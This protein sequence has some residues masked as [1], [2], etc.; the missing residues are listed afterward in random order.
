MFYRRARWDDKNR[1]A[2]FKR[3]YRL[4]YEIFDRLMS[5]RVPY[6]RRRIRN[7]VYT[8][9][10]YTVLWTE[11]TDAPVA[12]YTVRYRTPETKYDIIKR[13]FVPRTCYTPVM[14]TRFRVPLIY[15]VSLAV[16]NT[17]IRVRTRSKHIFFPPSL[18]GVIVGAMTTRVA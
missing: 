4:W 3:V 17:Y 1:R 12:P 13:V 6:T 9:L 8:K 5:A 7:P 10:V 18:P 15:S 16:L 11:E 2:C 14:Q